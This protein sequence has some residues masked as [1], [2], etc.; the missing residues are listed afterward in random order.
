MNTAPNPTAA[1]PAPWLL[2]LMRLLALAGA[3]IA[4]FLLFVHV[5]AYIAKTT[6]TVPFCSPIEWIDCNAVLNSRWGRWLGLPV[7]APALV[8]YVAAIAALFAVTRAA[9]PHGR[10]RMW[11]VLAVASTTIC[12]AA[13]WFIY[14]Q[15]AVI[16]KICTWCMAEHAIGILF[17]AAV[18]HHLVRGGALAGAARLQAVGAAALGV[19][20]L[21]GGQYFIEPTYI[22]PSGANGQGAAQLPPP[23]AGKLALLNGQHTLD[24][25]EY[26][27]VGKPGAKRF[28][29]ELIDYTCPRCRELTRNYHHARQ[30]GLIADDVAVVVAYFPIS[31]QCN[32]TFSETSPRHVYACA[33]ARIAAAVWL[34]DPS[35][36]EQFHYW[37]FDNQERIGERTARV[38]AGNLVGEAALNAALADPR[39]EALLKR[40]IALGG[41]LGLRSLP[42]VYFPT[43]QFTEIPEDPQSLARQINAALGGGT[44]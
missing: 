9:T 6:A 26:P 19:A 2:W 1:L 42:G 22:Q 30:Q 25:A 39:S 31:H 34:V 8:V 10:A 43:G 33:I 32:P 27:V 20:I 21:A 38:E 13:G 28:F 17:A 41:Q 18:W 4:G 23:P 36:Y 11:S 29:L 3:G 35:K 15:L 14:L 37:L 44:P 24:L 40:S 16:E 12:L 7:A 5:A